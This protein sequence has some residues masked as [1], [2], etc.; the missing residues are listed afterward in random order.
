[1]SEIPDLPPGLPNPCNDCPWRRNAKPGWLGPYSAE[2]WIKLAH[3]DQPIACHETIEPM[4]GEASWDQPGL[5]QCTGAAIYRANAMKSPRN[6]Q[7]AE[8]F[9]EP[10]EEK[11]FSDVMGRDFIAYHHGREKPAG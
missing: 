8:H 5:R 9:V 3:T 2:T 6:P 7:D 4:V 11:V 1:M 10:D